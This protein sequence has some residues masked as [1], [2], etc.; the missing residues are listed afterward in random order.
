MKRKYVVYKE[1][2]GINGK[3]QYVPK[4]IKAFRNET[5]ALAFIS[6]DKNLYMH[7]DMLLK[8]Q[9]TDGRCYNWNERKR[10]WEASV[11]K[12]DMKEMS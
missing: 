10:L 4:K 2:W 12:A 3:D 8:M 1:V 6:D 11:V 9:D 5:E 7:G